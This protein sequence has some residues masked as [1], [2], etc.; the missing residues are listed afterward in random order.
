[1]IQEYHPLI[2]W[3]SNCKSFIIQDA[4]HFTENV[5]SNYSNIDFET[6]KIQLKQNDFQFIS[7]NNNVSC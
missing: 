5:L 7:N 1:M 3:S 6:F 4:K 2:S